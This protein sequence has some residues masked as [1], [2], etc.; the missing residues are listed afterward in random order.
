[1]SGGWLGVLSGRNI[2]RLGRGVDI[3]FSGCSVPVLPELVFT[4]HFINIVVDVKASGPQH[5]LELCFGACSL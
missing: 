2:V 5:V 3:G 4:Q 1:M